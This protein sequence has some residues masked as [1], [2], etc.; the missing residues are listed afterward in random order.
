MLGSTPTKRPV[1][2]YE[3]SPGRQKIQDLTDKLN[4]LDRTEETTNSRRAAFDMR[5]KN[6]DDKLKRAYQSEDAP[7]LYIHFLEKMLI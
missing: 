4:S 3:V 2:G 1:S 6:I 5:L 7:Y